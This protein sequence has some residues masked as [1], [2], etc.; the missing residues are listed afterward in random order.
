VT[1]TETEIEP[2]GPA[3]R[4]NNLD[5]MMPVLL[6][7]VFYNVV[8]IKA[9]VIASTV[10]SIKAAVGRKRRG[11]DIGVWLP[12]ITIYLVARSIVTIMV[13]EEIVDFGVSSE[14]VYFGIGFITKILIGIAL[15]GTVFAGKPFLGWM[16]PR[17][18]PLADDLVADPRYRKTMGT[19]T[20]FIVVFEILTAIW[21]IWLFNNSGVNLFVVF[22]FGVNFTLGFVA[23]TGG[24]M[25]ID[26]KLEPIESY[27]GLS[28]L[29]ENSGRLNRS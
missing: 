7:L 22:R 24:L 20:M 13:D 9:A 28:E 8:N 15:A 18:V 2:S 3:R 23:I 14:A 29:M 1:E 25:Y 5:S 17:A 10:W 26:R 27:P 12:G 6:F 11:L 21:D 4:G 19:A 16:I